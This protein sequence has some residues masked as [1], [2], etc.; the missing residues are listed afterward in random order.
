MKKVSIIIPIYN[1][2]AYIE[3]CIKSVLNLTYKNTEIIC[4][5]DCSTDNSLKVIENYA[6]NDGRIKIISLEKN[7][8][9]SNARNI[10][11]K[12][13]TGE[14]VI[15]IDSDDWIESDMLTEGIKKIEAD[16][17]D[18]LC[19]G[20]CIHDNENITRI[21]TDA[22]LE[23]F[24]E[25]EP[26]DAKSYLHIAT[27]KIYKL[28]FIRKN[29]IKF[30]IGITASEDGVF[31]LLCLYKK[32]KFSLISRN[33]YNILIRQNSA[34]NANKNSV[35]NEIKSDKFLLNTKEFTMLKNKELK[36]ITFEKI[37]GNIEFYYN[38][39]NSEKFRFRYNL[40]ISLFILYL[41]LRFGKK[42]I[43]QCPNYKTLKSHFLFK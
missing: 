36:L 25:L 20:F 17:S 11:L 37:I 31:N 5:N 39:P 21:D 16:N 23:K 30:P 28:D 42:T 22:E 18:I 24:S 4:V 33:A 15:F 12:N 29:N 6:Q 38:R 27:A 2:E 14:Y 10:G 7:E 9:V 32:A 40:Q 41:Y 13:A 34:T 1:T 19:F 35:A 26:Q 3:R 8:G 43:K